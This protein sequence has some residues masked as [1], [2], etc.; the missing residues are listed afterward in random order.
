MSVNEKA[1]KLGEL[2]GQ[3][4]FGKVFAATKLQGADAGTTYAIKKIKTASA[5]SK[6]N[7]QKEINVSFQIYLL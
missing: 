7:I 1:F 2:L 5:I 4:A 3:G 6:A